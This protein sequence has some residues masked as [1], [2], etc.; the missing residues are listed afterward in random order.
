M[1]ISVLINWQNNRDEV[2]FFFFERE[3]NISSPYST[4]FSSSTVLLKYFKLQYHI[5]SLPPLQALFTATRP[6]SFLMARLARLTAVV[7]GTRERSK[8]DEKLMNSDRDEWV[9]DGL[10]SV[11]NS[12]WVCCFGF[13][14][15]NAR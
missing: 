3:D 11:L 12:G 7:G 14:F 8:R 5:C 6:T 9:L 1:K 10:V 13:G 4:S 2:F 15:G